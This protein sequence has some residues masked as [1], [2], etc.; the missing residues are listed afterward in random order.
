VSAPHCSAV[1]V[2]PFSDPGP[3]RCALFAAGESAPFSAGRS[4]TSTHAVR[5]TEYLP[6]RCAAVSLQSAHPRLWVAIQG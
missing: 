1:S 5:T 6:V 3:G 4:R 2:S